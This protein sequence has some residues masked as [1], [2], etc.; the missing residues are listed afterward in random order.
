MGTKRRKGSSSISSDNTTHPSK[1]I[2][3]SE[4]S[5]ISGKKIVLC[6][7]GSVAAYRAI[8]LAR[9]LMRHGANVYSV[10]SERVES[11]FVTSD[12]MKWATGNDVVT[13]LTGDLEHIVLADYN[14]SSL[15]LVYPCTANTIGKMVNG[16]DDTPV[17][18]VL[19]VALGSKIPIM[20]APAMHESMYDN[21]FIKKNISI[22]KEQGIVFLEPSV[23]EGK[24]KVAPIEQVL[25]SVINKFSN[26][27]GAVF[28]LSGKNILVT[29][30]STL[31][32][33]DPIRI[34]TNLSSGKMGI[35][36]ANEAKQMGANVTIV[37]GHGS[38]PHLDSLDLNVIQVN[39][40]E[41]M[42]DAV[43]AELSSKR[44]DI[45]I[46]AAAVTDFTPAGKKFTK[47]MDSRA[48]KLLLSLSPTKKIIDQVKHVS[49]NDI[50][51]VAFKAE[52]N[53]SNS[54]II[55]KA[56]QKLEECDGNLIVANDIGRKGSEAGSDNN[57]V[58]IIDR[59]K[60][61][62]HL[63]LQNKKD[64]AKKLLGIIAQLIY[65]KDPNQIGVD[66]K[67]SIG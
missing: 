20:I 11:T 21:Y 66:A 16:I 47:K 31:E 56:Y 22:L 4:G 43:I 10:M 44:Y 46:L 17:T 51:L 45:A 25:I 37:Y 42:Y 60:K 61:V 3:G 30:G 7:T 28:S 62:I 23:S 67:L 59:Q 64:I 53:V 13:K 18:S 58:F 57:E 26:P 52:H 9:L 35:A 15:I 55:K 1:D 5:E 19:S 8:D 54:H 63:P 34:I 32:H 14:K 65:T 48:G 33:I 24:A 12:M 41:Q 27:A 39:S 40:N 29:A 36:I 6:I 49:K 2:V 38:Y 50:F